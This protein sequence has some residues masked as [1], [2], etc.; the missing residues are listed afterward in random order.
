MNGSKPVVKSSPQAKAKPSRRKK[1][2]R[3]SQSAPNEAFLALMRVTADPDFAKLAKFDHIV[4]LMLENRSFDHMLGYLS[5]TG[6]RPDVDGLTPEMSN[7][8][9]S[10]RAHKVKELTQ[11]AFPHDPCHDSAC[12][13]EQLSGNNGG[14]VINFEKVDPS[15]PQ[16]IM[17]YYTGE[18]LPVYDHLAREY[19]ICNRWFSSTPGATWPNRLYAITGRAAGS[20][21]N[22]PHELPPFYNIPS[23]VRHLDT[24]QISWRWYC[25]HYF[26]SLR[27]IDDNYRLGHYDKFAYFGPRFLQRQPSFL[28]DVA[29]DN[30]AAVSWIDPSFINAP[31]VGTAGS[32]DD[33]PPSDILHGQELVLRLYNSIKSGPKW[34]RTLLVIVYDEHGG[35]FDHVKVEKAADDDANFRTYG[36]RVPAFVISPYVERGHASNL[37]FD[38]TSIIKTILLR[39]CSQAD[40]SVPFM[41]T[42]VQEAN[43]L[44]SLL[45]RDTPKK[46]APLTKIINTIAARRTEMFKD[47]LLLQATGSAP[48]PAPLN[49]LQ[50]GL[51]AAREKLRAEG[52]P[53]DQP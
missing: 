12:V 36:V 3:A 11:T 10:G 20:K 51:I 53:E 33:H 22:P 24:A 7:K 4:V 13:A 30:L 21:D 49:E 9:K 38:H 29:N 31:F 50:K 14:F 35:F 2:G 19:T 25:H 32:N 8:D 16:L 23:F 41:G 15:N 27:V 39:F 6:K 34:D 48:L 43:H 52:L 18:D 37:I 1:V 26:G 47:N 42:R 44:G 17:G 45:T 28:E 40:G 46:A 5:L